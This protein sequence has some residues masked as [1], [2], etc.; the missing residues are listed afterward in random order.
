MVVLWIQGTVTTGDAAANHEP[1]AA[2]AM[3]QQ[4]LLFLRQMMGAQRAMAADSWGRSAQRQPV[5]RRRL[6]LQARPD[7]VG[8]VALIGRR[9]PEEVTHFY[10]L[11]QICRDDEQFVTRWATNSP[12]RSQR[13]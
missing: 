7:D 9:Q 13:E 6:L 5:V 12:G 10:L 11:L 4:L 3:H 8:E 2:I 1:H